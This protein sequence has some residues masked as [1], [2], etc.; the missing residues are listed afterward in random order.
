[1]K[2]WA[3]NSTDIKSFMKQLFF[4]T[5]AVCKTEIPALLDSWVVSITKN[6][7]PYIFLKT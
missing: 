7:C 3:A 1:M 2:M 6:P 5:H 4:L